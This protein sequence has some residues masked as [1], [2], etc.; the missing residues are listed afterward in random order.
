MYLKVWGKRKLLSH[1]EGSFK[2]VMFISIVHLICYILLSL[3]R[4]GNWVM[5]RSQEWVKVLFIMGS[6]LYGIFLFKWLCKL[7]VL[8]IGLNLLSFFMEKIS[9]EGQLLKD[10]EIYIFLVQQEQI[11]EKWDF[12][13]Q[14]L[15]VTQRLAVPFW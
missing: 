4:I 12:L 6:S 2:V 8:R 1:T 7:Q 11:Q 10:T 15:P 14:F 9:L 3:G 13:T 5:G